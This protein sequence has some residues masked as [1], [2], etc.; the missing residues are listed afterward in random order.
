[1][2]IPKTPEARPGSHKTSVIFMQPVSGW[3][4]HT[5]ARRFSLPTMTGS[6]GV[7]FKRH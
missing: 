3:Q 2:K 5:L 6:P 1:M 4:R 7:Y